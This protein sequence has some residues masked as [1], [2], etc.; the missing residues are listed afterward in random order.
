MAGSD[1][2]RQLEQFLDDLK[3]N[4]ID[5]RVIKPF[6]DLVKLGADKDKLLGLIREEVGDDEYSSVKALLESGSSD[7][8]TG[9]G[10]WMI[11]PL[12]GLF[13]TPLFAA[14][15]LLV[16]VVPMFE[17]DVWRALTV[18][19]GAG[20]HPAW[21]PV[22]Y[23]SLAANVLLVAGSITLI[24]FM[25]RKLALFPKGMVVFYLFIFIISVA[26]FLVMQFVM[27]EAFPGMMNE[28]QGELTRGL[29]RSL[30]GIVIWVPYF[31][32]SQRVKNTFVN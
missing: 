30:V 18:P 14:R 3:S 10:G 8:P 23:V 17:S 12:I 16:D 24:Y 25:F 27:A 20:Y 7:A 32:T 15:A 19:G 28:V 9:I 11:L 5:D 6:N 22:G 4:K 31:M 26:E 13:L 2:D 21:A 1:L 29:I